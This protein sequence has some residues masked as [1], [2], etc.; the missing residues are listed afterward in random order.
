MKQVSLTQ[1]ICVKDICLFL[2]DK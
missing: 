2:L 1:T